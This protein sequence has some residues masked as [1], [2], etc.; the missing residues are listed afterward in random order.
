LAR[1][2]VENRSKA[3]DM[4]T[5]EGSASVTEGEVEDFTAVVR[6]EVP[7]SPFDV[8]LSK[9]S[10]LILAVRDSAAEEAQD[11][12]EAACRNEWLEI[13]VESKPSH[14]RTVA[15]LVFSPKLR[16]KALGI[17][18]SGRYERVIR[19]QTAIQDDDSGSFRTRR[20]NSW[21][22]LK[23]QAQQAEVELITRRQIYL[24]HVPMVQQLFKAAK[25]QPQSAEDDGLLVEDVKNR[26]MSDTAPRLEGLNHSLAVGLSLQGP[27]LH[28][29]H[30]ELGRRYTLPPKSRPS[31]ILP[32]PSFDPLNSEEKV[33]TNGS[34]SRSDLGEAAAELG[35]TGGIGKEDDP[36]LPFL[37]HQ[38]QA[39][40]G[41]EIF[42]LS[43]FH[44]ELH[45]KSRIKGACFRS[46][47]LNSLS[48]LLIQPAG[49]P[50]WV[51]R[52][53]TRRRTLGAALVDRLEA[54]QR[55]M[56]EGIWH[57]GGASRPIASREER[58][59]GPRVRAPRRRDQSLRT[60]FL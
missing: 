45:Q 6:A 10:A 32:I 53:Q 47:S 16:H 55:E 4:T 43:A 33:L 56:A 38:L 22:G 19:C 9:A 21:N 5:L 2:R 57:P 23:L 49:M 20:R 41:F 59:Y 13:P 14:D 36:R 24:A 60:F 46:G 44:F 51:V 58:S 27:E 35:K 54:R 50:D 31:S 30:K 26:E 7:D 12:C 1:Q 37:A 18:H 28:V 25:G 39:R 34:P 8:L 48:Q 11:R 3:S 29:Y 42:R 17:P 52:R 40:N 15:V